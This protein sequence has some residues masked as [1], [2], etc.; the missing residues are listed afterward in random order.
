MDLSAAQK[1]VII[2]GGQAGAQVVQSLRQFGYEGDLVLVGDEAA[3]PYQR[4]P[5]SKAYMKGELGEDRLYFKP[6]AWYEDN[7]VETLLSQRVEKIDRARRQVTLEHGG[8]LDYDALIIATGSRPRPL[9]VEGADLENVFDLRGLADVEHIQP[10]MIP[11]HRLVI[12]GAGYIGLEAAAVARQLGLEVRVLEMEQRALARV[13][14]PVISSFYEALHMEHG[15]D[16]RCGARLARLKG[17]DGKLTHAVLASGEEIEA[18]MVL[19]GI[20][21]VPNVELAED[22]GLPVKNG[23]IVDEDAR[24]S[25]PRIFAA[26]DCTV[27]PLAH[28]AR[29]GRLES[30]HNAIEQGKLAAAA[31]MG[32]PRPA[33]DCPWFWS[34]QYDIKLQIAGLSMG[35][36]E[37]VVR[38]DIE[39]KKFAAFYLK[40]GLLIAVD[41]INS[42]PEFIASKRL[43][44]SGASVA[45]ET[46]KDTSISMKEIAAQAA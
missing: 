8:H 21:I 15:V 40:N 4:P 12:V 26:G 29:T 35:Y 43:I 24:T 6:A 31:I 2:G 28:Y 5:L 25:D 42:P 34:D 18:D 23:I 46:L 3:L 32:K 7:K 44:M 16:V 1:I 30:V 38:G 22:A 13:T 11:G 39:A 17:E 9:P 41:A 27:R 36:D 37:I 33:L 14:S 19:A 45:S 20:G 10:K